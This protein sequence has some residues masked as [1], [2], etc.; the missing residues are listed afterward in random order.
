MFCGFLSDLNNMVD[1]LD[2]LSKHCSQLNLCIYVRFWALTVGKPS[3]P[4]GTL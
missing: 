1:Y 4:S 2:Y 3:K